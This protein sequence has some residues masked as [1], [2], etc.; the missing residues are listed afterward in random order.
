MPEKGLK[1]AVA[2][3]GAGSLSEVTG[4]EGFAFYLRDGSAWVEA[5]KASFGF[6]NVS[7]LCG[8]RKRLSELIEVL[9]DTRAILALGFPGVSRDVLSR[10]GYVL[11]ETSVFETEVLDGILE[12]LEKGDPEDDVV[13]TAPY[14]KEAG[15][16][17]YFLDLRLALNANPD[18]TTKKILRPFFQNVGFVEL[19]FIYDHFPPWLIGELGT[20]GYRY[21]SAEARGGVLVRVFGEGS[22]CDREKS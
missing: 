10:N 1:I 8:M 13:P 3:D 15:S 2:L 17:V 19:E 4:A 20:L 16:G 5:G 6:E 22:I 11:Y 21:E 18:L 14:E 12:H 9:E 7:G